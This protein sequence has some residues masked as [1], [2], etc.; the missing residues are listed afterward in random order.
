MQHVLT[1]LLLKSNRRSTKEKSLT[2][3]ISHN[4]KM[5]AAARKIMTGKEIHTPRVDGFKYRDT[6]PVHSLKYIADRLQ[7]CADLTRL[8]AART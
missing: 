3:R 7:L 5:T 8:G 6:T 4:E 1:N 2:T